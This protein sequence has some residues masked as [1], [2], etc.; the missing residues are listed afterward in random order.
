M[1]E[2]A[3]LRI[4]D[5]QMHIH[6]LQLNIETSLSENNPKHYVKNWP[7]IVKTAEKKIKE[8]Q[9]QCQEIEW[10]EIDDSDS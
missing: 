6:D 10:N 8:L 3:K 7:L 4:K 2:E 9:Q 1:T 5:V